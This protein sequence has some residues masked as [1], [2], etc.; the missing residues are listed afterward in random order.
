MVSYK[1]HSDEVTLP[2]HMRCCSQ[3]LYLIDTTDAGEVLTDTTYKKLY[4]QC[5]GKATAL[6][7][8]TSTSSKAADAVYAILGYRLFVP[9]VTRWN[10][11]YDAMNKIMSAETKLIEVCKAI[12]LSTFVQTEIIFLEY[13]EVMGPLAASLDILPGDQHCTFGFVLPTI[14]VLKTKLM[15]IDVK[16]TK[17]L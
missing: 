3:M 17:P 5:M 16:H 10:S 1:T 11:Y 4:R 13:I 14:T 6:W 7:N 8:L 12:S 15:N 2:D 9:C